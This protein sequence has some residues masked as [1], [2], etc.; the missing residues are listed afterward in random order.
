MTA[1]RSASSD[2]IA[3]EAGEAAAAWEAL[4]DDERNE[5]VEWYSAPRLSTTIRRLQSALPSH[6]TKKTLKAA[7]AVVRAWQ[8]L[9]GDIQDSIATDYPDL[10]AAVL[11]LKYAVYPKSFNRDLKL[12]G[13]PAK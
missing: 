10:A 2:S 1:D 9:W 13:A 11:D 8:G 12:L 6:D 5:I 7:R 3:K 4:S